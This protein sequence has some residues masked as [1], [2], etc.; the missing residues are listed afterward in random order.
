MHPQVKGYDGIRARKMVIK[1]RRSHS[2][3]HPKSPTRNFTPQAAAA[4]TG[5]AAGAAGALSA[6]VSSDFGSVPGAASE[7]G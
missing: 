2:R 4:T 6:G 1:I 3:E 7:A 5:A